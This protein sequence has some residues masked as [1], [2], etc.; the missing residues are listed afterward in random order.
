MRTIAN[1]F[2]ASVNILPPSQ[3][4][5]S[6]QFCNNVKFCRREA[7]QIYFVRE[8]EHW[9]RLSETWR[10]LSKQ[11]IERTS[12]RARNASNCSSA[13]KRSFGRPASCAWFTCPVGRLPEATGNTRLGRNHEV[14]LS[15]SCLNWLTHHG[16]WMKLNLEHT[17]RQISSNCERYTYWIHRTTLLEICFVDAHL[18]IL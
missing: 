3:P 15:R 17:N 1:I 12:S 5:Y 18:Y 6:E 16:K 7:R 14:D 9:S 13:T 8:I 10:I 4:K 11:N 2:C